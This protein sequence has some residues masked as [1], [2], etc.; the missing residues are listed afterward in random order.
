[1]SSI[2]F[3]TTKQTDSSPIVLDRMEVAVDR[4]FE[5]YPTE[6]KSDD[7]SSFIISTSEQMPEIVIDLI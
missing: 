2:A 5:Q 6:S 3:T 7:D 1:V 4:T